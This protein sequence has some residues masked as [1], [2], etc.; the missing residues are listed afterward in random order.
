MTKRAMGNRFWQF[1]DF[2]QGHDQSHKACALLAGIV[3]L[4]LGMDQDPVQ[5]CQQ[6]GGGNH[7]E[8]ILCQKIIDDRSDRWTVG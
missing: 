1:H 8:L 7:D 6:L 5:F 3:A 4:K 2:A